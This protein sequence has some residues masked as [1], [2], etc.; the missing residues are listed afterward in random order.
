METV[1]QI[2]FL[3]GVTKLGGY[4]CTYYPAESLYS[5]CRVLEYKCRR[6]NCHKKILVF[7]LQHP[8][9]VVIASLVPRESKQTITT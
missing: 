9:A 3:Q 6:K 8:T 4:N 2:I 1:D 5:N 7:V